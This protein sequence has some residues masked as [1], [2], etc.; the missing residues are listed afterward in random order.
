MI[1]KPMVTVYQHSMHLSRGYKQH[2][3]IIGCK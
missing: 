2:L 3:E 1:S